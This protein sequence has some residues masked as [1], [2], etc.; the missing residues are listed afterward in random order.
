MHEIVEYIQKKEAICRQ[1]DSFQADGM[2]KCHL[3]FPVMGFDINLS[4]TNHPIV[5]LDS[6][7]FSRL[8]LTNY[9]KALSRAFDCKGNFHYNKV[10]KTESK[11]RLE[12]EYAIRFTTKRGIYSNEINVPLLLKHES[13]P[14][15]ALTTFTPTKV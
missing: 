8:F 4:A 15:L 2:K 12:I 14:S 1:A 11:E 13:L 10:F 7:W 3:P 9:C 6:N 5:A